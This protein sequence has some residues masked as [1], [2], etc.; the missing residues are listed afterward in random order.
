MRNMI[1]LRIDVDYAYPSRVKSFLQTAFNMKARRDYLKNAKIIAKMINESPEEIKSYWFFTPK[2]IPDKELLDILEEERHEVALHIAKS[3][4]E[5]MKL[6]EKATGRKLNYYTIHGTSRLFAR[7]IW[8]R[9]KSKAPEIPKNFPL[10]S[11]HQFPISGLDW[12]CYANDSAIAVRRA[13][14][15]SANGRVLH[16]HPVWL[17]QRGTINHRGPFYDAFRKILKV[18]DEMETTA[19]KKKLFFK[20]ASG[21]QEYLKDG[22]PTEGFIEK[23]A[24]I[25]VDI[26]TFVERKWCC[27]LANPPKH[28]T[29]AEDNVALLQITTYDQWW[30]DIGKKTRNMVRKAEKNGVETRVV[31]PDEKLAEG[32]W[33]IYNESPIRQERDFP[34]YGTSLQA[35]TRSVLAARDCTF[36][37][38]FFQGELAGFVQ[39]LHNGEGAMVSQILSLQKHWD[40]SV[41]NAL[42]AKAV[43]YCANDKIR[44][45]MYGRM[46]NHPSLDKFKQSNGFSKFTVARYYVPITRKGR[47]AVKLGL[48]REIK[49]VLPEPLKTGLIPL[50]NWVSRNKI[51][52]KQGSSS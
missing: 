21:K 47:L 38:S 46:G 20:V 33:K 11:F 41:N 30:G 39:L 12:M 17:F 22:N 51:R 44:W 42:I 26:L 40:K 19:V 27:P 50:Y 2:T 49:D 8:K 7:V 32:I 36:I 52:V 25:G 23:L 16:I 24:G 10:K 4:Y 48:H 34:H 13:K 45:I 3:P 43:E 14:K 18:D 15:D 6:L 31:E 28:W 37:G 9:W 29:K 1:K 5:E 35:V